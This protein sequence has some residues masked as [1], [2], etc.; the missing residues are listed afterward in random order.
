MAGFE[1]ELE[2]EKML[3]GANQE[4]EGGQEDKRLE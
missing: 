2:T 1:G 3:K 4:L